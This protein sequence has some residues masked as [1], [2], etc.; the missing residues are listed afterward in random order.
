[1]KGL[2]AESL[3]GLHTFQVQA[4]PRS[5]GDMALTRA[6][7]VSLRIA[8]VTTQVRRPRNKLGTT[9]SGPVSDGWTRAGRPN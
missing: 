5:E 7:G 3:A 2:W 9:S 6:S 1:M 4:G 8:P